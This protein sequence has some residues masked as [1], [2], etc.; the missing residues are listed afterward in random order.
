MKSL[1]DVIFEFFDTFC[2]FDR[3]V[4]VVYKGTFE[5]DRCMKS[6]GEEVLNKIEINQK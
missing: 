1:K 3:G 4:Y 5:I 2:V 6:L